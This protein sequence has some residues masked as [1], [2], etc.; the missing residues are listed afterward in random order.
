MEVYNWALEGEVAK[1]GVNCTITPIYKKGT[2]NDPKNYH[3]IALLSIGRKV[4]SAVL[5]Q[6]EVAASPCPRGGS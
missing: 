3:V 1:E 4:F 2:P 5:T 6:I